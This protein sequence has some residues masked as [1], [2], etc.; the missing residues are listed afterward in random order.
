MPMRARRV[1]RADALTQ[2]VPAVDAS[3]QLE[4]PPYR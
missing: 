1:A 4:N 3:R 2:S